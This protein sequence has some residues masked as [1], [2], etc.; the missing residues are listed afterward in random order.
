M[1]KSANFCEEVGKVFP[2]A[3]DPKD[4]I[5]AKAAELWKRLLNQKNPIAYNSDAPFIVYSMAAAELNI[6]PAQ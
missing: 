1:G 5:N 2:M 4:P 6:K 3:L